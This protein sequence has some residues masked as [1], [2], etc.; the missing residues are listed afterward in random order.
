MKSIIS[1]ITVTESDYLYGQ[2]VSVLFQRLTGQEVRVVDCLVVGLSYKL[3]ADRLGLSMNTV[4]FHIKNT[5][6]KLG[7]N[8]KVEVVLLWSNQT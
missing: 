5:Y 4:C 7:V 6:R 3:I 1:S 2:Q 8:S